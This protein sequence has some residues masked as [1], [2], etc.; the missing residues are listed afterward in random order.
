MTALK[1]QLPIAVVASL[2]SA[3][4][5][6]G[7]VWGTTK[8]EVERTSASVAKLEAERELHSLRLQALELKMD[9]ALSA[10]NRI[11]ARVSEIPAPAKSR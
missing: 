9:L 10:L 4:A 11:E 2:L 1:L 8:G 5:G 3:T 6:A 7:V